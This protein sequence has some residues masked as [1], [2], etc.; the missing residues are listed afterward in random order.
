MA[1]NKVI[2]V[3]K[4]ATIKHNNYRS[5]LLTIKN[6]G[7]CTVTKIS[8]QLNLSKTAISKA[9]VSLQAQGFIE[10]VGKGDSS[11]TGGKPADLYAINPI[12]RYTCAIT[13]YHEVIIVRICDFLGN[14]VIQTTYSHTAT[15]NLNSEI[16]AKYSSEWILNTCTSG[17]IP[18]EKICGIIFLYD[19]NNNG[20][21]SATKLLHDIKTNAQAQTQLNQFIRQ[22]LKINCPVAICQ[23][24]NM[25]GY[26]VLQEDNNRRE[27][28]VAV[29]SIMKESVSGCLLHNGKIIEGKTESALNIAHVPVSDDKKHLCSCGQYGCYSAVTLKDNILADLYDA[30]KNGE[31]SI[32][33]NKSKERTLHI[34]DVMNAYA[35]GDELAIKTMDKVLSYHVKLIYL[36]YLML[37]P[38]EI[39]FQ[40]GMGGAEFHRIELNKRFSTLQLPNKSSEPPITLSVSNLEPFDATAIGAANYC[41]DLYLS[42]PDCFG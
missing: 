8:E 26:A 16:L 39:V 7:P 40:V 34:G 22:Y 37:N 33:L 1:E 28:M 18:P 31:P 38:D 27:K 20:T 15:Y 13:F 23:S 10:V 2:E 9:I 25:R 5:I 11:A 24:K 30:F 35:Q 19:I 6:I 42:L 41:I 3:L 4:P 14:T 12:C 29:V 17:S 36:I 32:L 21:F